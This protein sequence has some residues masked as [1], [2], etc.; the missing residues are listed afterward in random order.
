MLLGWIGSKKLGQPVRAGIGPLAHV[1]EN[2]A[3]KWP[4]GSVLAHDLVRFGRQLFFPIRVRQF[5]ALRLNQSLGFGIIDHQFAAWCRVHGLIFSGNDLEDGNGRHGNGND[6]G[7]FLHASRGSVRF[8]YGK[9][10]F[11]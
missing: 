1:L 7:S 3:G 11:K 10:T 2:P 8:L 5:N 9:H 6:N 4:F